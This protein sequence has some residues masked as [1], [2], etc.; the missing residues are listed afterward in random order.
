[1]LFS[2]TYCTY[3]GM[4]FG[5]N[6]SRPF[7]IAVSLLQDAVGAL[8]THGCQTHIAKQEQEECFDPPDAGCLDALPPDD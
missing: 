6:P 2:E 4:S 5:T 1:M 7:G 3:S 8:L